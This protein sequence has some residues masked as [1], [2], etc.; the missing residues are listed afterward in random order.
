LF[1][2][3]GQA[4]VQGQPGQPPPQPQQSPGSPGGENPAAQNL[5]KQLGTNQPSVPPRQ[6][7]GA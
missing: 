2:P 6:P 5:L 4:P 1:P 3:K 7:F